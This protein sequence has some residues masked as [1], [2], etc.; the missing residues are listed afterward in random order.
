MAAQ[1][2]ADV[3]LANVAALAAQVKPKGKTLDAY[4]EERRKYLAKNAALC[5]RLADSER[6]F[7][8]VELALGGAE[9][10]DDWCDAALLVVG[11][12]VAEGGA[13][14]VSDE[15]KRRALTAEAECDRLRALAGDGRLVALP[16][17]GRTR[18]VLRSV[19]DEPAWTDGPHKWASIAAAAAAEV[20]PCA[21]CDTPSGCKG[22]GRCAVPAVAPSKPVC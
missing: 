6:R 8:E 14:V 22:I 20:V 19:T 2:S 1:R 10:S 7:G 15:W 21:G 17:T 16:E 18:E 4:I 11:E 5:E 12:M 3:A 13:R 9:A